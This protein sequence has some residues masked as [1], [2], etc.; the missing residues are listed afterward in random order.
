MLTSWLT[1]F[2]SWSR[3]IGRNTATMV[4][5][6]IAPI[7]RRRARFLSCSSSSLIDFAIT[8]LGSKRTP[9]HSV[10]PRDL[11]LTLPLTHDCSDREKRS[12]HDNFIIFCRNLT[13]SAPCCANVF[14]LPHWRSNAG[15]LQR[16]L[17]LVH[18]RSAWAFYSR[19]VP[20]CD[21]ILDRVDHAA[22]VL[23]LQ[24]GKNRNRARGLRQAPETDRKRASGLRVM[25][26]VEDPLRTA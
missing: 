4:T 11:C 3:T 13:G 17:E 24:H 5:K 14:E 7:R 8:D 2:G 16:R 9:V 6:A 15:A 20:M 26:H 12:E 10:G 18:R 1:G 19:R 23:V 21:A 25:R 22:N